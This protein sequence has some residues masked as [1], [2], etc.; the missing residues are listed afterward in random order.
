MLHVRRVVGPS[1]VPAFR[2]GAIVL[3]LKWLR[4]KVGSVVVAEHEGLELIKR[5]A[6]VGVRGFYLLG[7]NAR[8]STDSREYGWFTPGSIKSVIIGSLKR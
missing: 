1:M 5:V 4:P 7:D 6:K 8:Q 2:P 3:G